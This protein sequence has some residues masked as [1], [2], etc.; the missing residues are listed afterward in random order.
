MQTQL[1]RGLRIVPLLVCLLITAHSAIAQL[2]HEP[3]NY[4]AGGAPGNGGTGWAAAWSPG[5]SQVISPG[6]TF[7]GVTP[8][9]TANALGPSG[10]FA[11]RALQTPVAGAA[12]TSL[13]LRAL[14]RSDVNGTPATQATLGNSPGGPGK[15]FII[16]DLP[17]PDANAGNWGLQNDCGRFY[18]NVPVVANQTVY[19]VAQIDFNVSGTNDRMRLW[20][21]TTPPAAA[22]L[23]L[24]P[25]VDVMCN[26]TTFGGVFWQTQQGQ[27]VDE[28][29]IDTNQTAC[30][31]PPNTTMVGWYPFDE[32]SGTFAANLATGNTGKL[33]NSP[34]HVTG[35][36]ARALSFD[37]VDDYVQSPSTIVTN[38]GPAPWPIPANCNSGNYSTCRGDFSIDA[39]VKVD[40]GASS[41]AIV[42][43]D[44]RSGSPPAI[45]GYSLAVYQLNR[46]VLQLADGIGTGYSNYLSPALSPSLTDG[47]WH[48]VAVTVLR[49][50]GG[51]NGV[52]RWYHNGA[53]VFPNTATNRWGSL[54]NN[55][56]LR[57][58]TRTAASPLTGWFKGEIDELEIFNRVLT[59]TEVADIYNAGPFGKCK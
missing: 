16:G 51:G 31:P 17:M 41:A 1:K 40:P 49:R 59:A 6:L 37:G 39:W 23:T 13:I 42:I 14:M 22:Y 25:D 43:V 48:H 34:T 24:T 4:P 36:V 5:S 21:Q 50:S 45:K 58:G 44:K 54:A 26:V 8:A 33:I 57:I 32:A 7:A 52:I 30:A 12:G 27:A 3:F 18:S 35:M 38:F 53:N 55:S 20:V 11:S 9:P 19:L 56:P 15:N 2:A 10:A 46:L 28:I 29:R 47:Q